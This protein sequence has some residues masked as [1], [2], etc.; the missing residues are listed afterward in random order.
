MITWHYTYNGADTRKV[1]TRTINIATSKMSYATLL[2]LLLMY[3]DSPYKKN[4][5]NI[6]YQF[7]NVQNMKVHN[8]IGPIIGCIACYKVMTHYI[9][10]QM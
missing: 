1:K 10:T 4:V 6:N 9:N 7:V 3:D 8:I 5:R 2:F